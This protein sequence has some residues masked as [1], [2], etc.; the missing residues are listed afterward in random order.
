MPEA[1][2]LKRG[3]VQTFLVQIIFYYHAN[4][5]HFHKKGFALGLVLRV[6]GF[7]TRKWPIMLLNTA[8]YRL[9]LADSTYGLFGY[10]VSDDIPRDFGG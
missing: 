5:T 2:V 3:Q 7:G 1:S 10:Q 4:K 9:I 6:R 8:E